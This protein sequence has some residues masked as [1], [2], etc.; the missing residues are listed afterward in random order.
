MAWVGVNLTGTEQLDCGPRSPDRLVLLNTLE[1]ADWI[2]VIIH[3]AG[4]CSLIW[5]DNVKCTTDMLVDQKRNYCYLL[6][7]SEDET[8][9]SKSMEI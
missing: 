7:V 6:I 9:R 4:K 8:I 1:L 2:Y 5:S 3:T